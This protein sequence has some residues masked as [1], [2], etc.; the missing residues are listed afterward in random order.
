MSTEVQPVLVDMET[1]A[2]SLAI[3]DDKLR[4][5]MHA[6]RINAQKLGS[7]IVFRPEE[8]QRYANDLPAWEPS[9]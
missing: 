5:E 2:R 4:Q 9:K 7:K 3:S 8:L 6:G 1:A